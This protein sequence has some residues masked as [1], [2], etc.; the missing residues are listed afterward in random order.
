[1]TPNTRRLHCRLRSTVLCSLGVAMMFPASVLAFNPNDGA[2]ADGASSRRRAVTSKNLPST[3]PR[4]APLP[5][6]VFP[7]I[8]PPRPPVAQPVAAVAPQPVAAPMA[9]PPVDAATVA[10]AERE[11]RPA[12][13]STSPSI[14]AA[15]SVVVAASPNFPPPAPLVAPNI[16]A[17]KPI[18]PLANLPLP[19]PV[20]T[21]ASPEPLAASNLKDLP[22]ANLPALAPAP[23][24]PVQA[25]ATLSES[26]KK[27]IAAI[28]SKL[29]S[30]PAKVGAGK[31]GAVEIKRLSPTVSAA[32]AAN[33]KVERYDSAGISI[34]VAREGLDSN[35]ELNRAYTALMGGDTTTAI[36]TYKN[37]LT[38][39]PSNQD[40]LFGLAS[41]YHR[42]GKLE[43]ARPYYAQL[44]KLNPEHREGLNNFLAL[45]SD[46]APQEALAELERLEQRNPQFSP[47]PAQQAVVLSKLG[48]HDQ[49]REKMLR[50]IELAPDNLTYKY[51][52]AVMLDRQGNYADAGA[53]YRLL[54]D[55][56]LHGE[57]IPSPLETIQKR[58]NFIVSANSSTSAG[59]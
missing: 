1:M 52:L 7:E 8:L 30:E 16:A 25:E 24:P 11:L 23:L 47:I 10:R 43:Q 39:E 37:L 35:F 53:L 36:A 13:A 54:I 55:A 2:G 59:S 3:T 21:V 50:A 14:V 4:V 58:L 49:A 28:P 32:I 45:I 15:P 22:P 41:T 5:K 57:K 19:V 40:A 31:S 56:S 20:Q 27:V 48:Y 42:Q 51:N 38:T 44:L 26:S 33:P 12:P 6:L 18:E 34:K 9:L 17:T 46:E 29:H